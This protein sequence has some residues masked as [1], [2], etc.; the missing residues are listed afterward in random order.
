M[1][2][3]IELLKEDTVKMYGLKAL[4]A[5]SWPDVPAPNVKPKL[6]CFKNDMTHLEML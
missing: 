4:S 5:N 2:A 1:E 6:F 3:T